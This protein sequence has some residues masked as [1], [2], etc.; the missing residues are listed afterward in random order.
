MKML[1]CANRAGIKRPPLD[2]LAMSLIAFLVIIASNILGN[3]SSLANGRACMAA[4]YL[5]P[6]VH[7][8]IKQMIYVHLIQR[9]HTIRGC[10]D[11]AYPSTWQSRQ[12]HRCKVDYVWVFLM[13]LTFINNTALAVDFGFSVRHVYNLDDLTCSVGLNK[14]GRFHPI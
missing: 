2:L 9:L 1:F 14:R 10:V 3:A 12:I 11:C 8:I 6:M 5:S 4:A 7:I 13:L